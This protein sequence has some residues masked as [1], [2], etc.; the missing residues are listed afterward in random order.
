MDA[1]KLSNRGVESLKVFLEFAETRNLDTLTEVGAD[2]ESPFERSVIRFLEAEGYQVHPQVGCAGFRIDLAIPDPEN[3]GKYLL[4]I[5]CDGASY[6]SSPVARARDRQRQ[7]VLEDRGWRIHR[8]WSTD[9]YRE[10]ESTKERLLTAVEDALEREGSP[11]PGSEAIAEDGGT[12]TTETPSIEELQGD[13]AGISLEDI[14]Q[15]YTSATNVPYSKLSDY[16]VR[17]T[18]KAVKHVVAEEGPIHRELLAKRIV[19]RSDVERRGKKVDQTITNAIEAAS[20]QGDITIDGEFLYPDTREDLP[21]RRREGEEADI[22][23]IPEGEI[24]T[25]VLEVIERQYQ[26]PKEDL[27]KQVAH[28]LGFSRTGSRIS[29]QIGSIIATMESDGVLDAT[30]GRLSIEEVD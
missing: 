3:P 9:W 13:E 28:V 8:V 27:I 26:T 10:Q 1:S 12:E 15:D 17:T 20:E 30:G 29:Q 24:R 22:E 18:L 16:D 7:S 4:G 21:V 6:H 19:R 11:G 23:W 5:E 25:A 2:P 14:G